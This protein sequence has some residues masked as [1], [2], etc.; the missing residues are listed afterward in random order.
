MDE[1]A[2]PSPADAR[3]VTPLDA[4]HHRLGARMA[5]FAGYSL[6]LSYPSGAI[7]EHLHTRAKASLFDVSHM[8]QAILT[9]R[10]AARLLETLVPADLDGLEPQRTRYTQ[11][12]AEDGGILDDL[13][14]TR[15]PGREERLLLVVNAAGKEQDFTLLRQELPQLQLSVLSGRALLALQGPRA[16]ATLSTI[17]PG[18]EDAPFMGWLPAEYEGASVFVSRSGYTGEDGFEIS[19]P[20]YLATRLAERLLANEDVA[21]AGLAARDS[22]RLEAGLCLYGHDIDATT[23]PVEAGLIW[24]IGKRRRE[25]GGFPGF[26]RIRAA[27]DNGP[28]RRRVGLLPQS[29]APLRD[30]ATLTAPDGRIVGRI[31]SGGYSP[32]LARPIAMGMVESAFATPG[33]RLASELR[34]KPIEVEVATLPFVPHRYASRGKDRA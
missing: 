4:L 11:L 19:A 15:L 17:L 20:A 8:G 24:S 27:I 10:G 6:P 32:S 3:A 28:A 12:L 31:T 30:G 9:G 5:P 1:H 21:P 22:L 18:V 13:M 33:I 25:Q 23:D 34:G 26:A 29:K 14:A 2:L 7:A 16:A